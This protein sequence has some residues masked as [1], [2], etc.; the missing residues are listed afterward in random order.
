MSFTGAE[1]GSSYLGSHPSLIESLVCR[2]QVCVAQQGNGQLGS[3]SVLGH[4]GQQR[5][6]N[7][8]K[9]KQV[10][11]DLLRSPQTHSEDSA[12]T[13]AL[14]VKKVKN[15]SPDPEF[16]HYRTHGLSPEGEILLLYKPCYFSQEAT[17]KHPP[18]KS[19]TR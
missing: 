14:Q 10:G 11:R 17:P 2:E 7:S 8:A 16:P 19:Q 9:R 1:A 12:P 6:N 13:H 4:R 15:L 3:H 5:H 18:S